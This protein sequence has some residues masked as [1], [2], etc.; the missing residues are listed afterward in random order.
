MKIRFAREKETKNTVR[1]QE[2]EEKGK[3]PVVGTLYVQK[4]AAGDRNELTIE[5]EE[6]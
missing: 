4:W 2:V 6:L 3:P 1:F 5:I